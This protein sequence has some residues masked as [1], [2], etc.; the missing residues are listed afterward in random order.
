[1]FKNLFCAIVLLAA[2]V[3]ARPP[4]DYKGKG[5]MKVYQPSPTKVYE[6]SPTKVTNIPPHK[7]YQPSPT[8][9]Y[10]PTPTKVY[11]PSPTMLPYRP[12]PTGKNAP[13]YMIH[14]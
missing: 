1:M 5:D 9:I 3:D 8:K 10:E 14:F 13:E 2:V 11:Q 7:V 6:P 12:A 4:P